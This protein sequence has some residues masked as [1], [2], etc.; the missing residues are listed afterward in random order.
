MDSYRYL[1]NEQAFK[2]IDKEVAVPD[3]QLAID[4]GEDLTP[5]PNYV[6]YPVVQKPPTVPNVSNISYELASIDGYTD[7]VKETDFPVEFYMGSP[8][9][10]F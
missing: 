4:F 10:G 7:P 2:A 8:I 6:F 1:Y 5:Q 9:G 3:N